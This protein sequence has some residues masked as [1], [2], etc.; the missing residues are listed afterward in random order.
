[1]AKKSLKEAEFEK[2]I[3]EHDFD[4]IWDWGKELLPPLRVYHE[5]K[6]FYKGITNQGHTNSI[7]YKVVD[8]IEAMKKEGRFVQAELD[9]EIYLQRMVKKY[10]YREWLVN[11][12]Y[13]LPY[14]KAEQVW[15]KYCIRLKNKQDNY[16]ENLNAIMRRTKGKWKGK[17]LSTLIKDQAHVTRTDTL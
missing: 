12:W 15:I 7:R 11:G 17:D 14:E 13:K 2:E 10:Y 9:S 5:Q 6:Y 8:F 1:M 3:L 4:D 16:L